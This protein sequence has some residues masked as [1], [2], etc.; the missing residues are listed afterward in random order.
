MLTRLY[1]MKENGIKTILHLNMLLTANE[2][3]IWINCWRSKKKESKTLTMFPDY[4]VTISW[5]SKFLNIPML[6]IVHDK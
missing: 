3:R 1:A 5:K 2:V 6:I 4:I